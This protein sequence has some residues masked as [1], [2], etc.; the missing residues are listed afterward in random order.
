[1]LGPSDIYIYIYIYDEFAEQSILFGIK[2]QNKKPLRQ[3]APEETNKK[4]NAK[5]DL[6]ISFLI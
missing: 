3:P 2:R 5:T 6:S 4:E 1:M